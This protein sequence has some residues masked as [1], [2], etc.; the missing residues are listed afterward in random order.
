MV[1]RWE[2]GANRPNDTYLE[3]LA[4]V[5]DVRVADFLSAGRP[6][7]ENDGAPVSPMGVP[8]QLAS[9]DE[10]LRRIETMLQAALAIDADAQERAAAEALRTLGRE[11]AAA[12]QPSR[13]RSKRAA[14][15]G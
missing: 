9:I 3:R 11:A 15:A 14:R 1:S 12:T 6:S 4:T 10:R 2:R 7:W 5:L 8:A 13:S